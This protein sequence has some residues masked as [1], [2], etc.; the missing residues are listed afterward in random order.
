MLKI[1]DTS[2][3]EEIGNTV[4]QGIGVLLGITALIILLRSVSIQNQTLHFIGSIIYGITL[5]LMF[6]TSGIFHGF[7]FTKA[8]K[9]L[10]ILDNAA[11][12][13]FIAGSFTILDFALLHG[14]FRW[15]SLIIV[16]MIAFAG[17]L[18]TI[19]YTHKETLLLTIFLIFGWV[20]MVFIYPLLRETSYIYVTLFLSGG[21]L[22]T[23][24][25]IF[26]RWRNLLFHHT[27]W[28]LFIIAACTLHFILIFNLWNT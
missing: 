15:I 22:F 26:L 10:Y 23:L 20:G 17:I 8:R 21:I 7:Y 14:V 27:I 19:F 16:W 24:G 3:I 4:T 13:T 12:F 9:I 5:I 6:L 18:V 28:H 11:I 2:K 25:T 1:N